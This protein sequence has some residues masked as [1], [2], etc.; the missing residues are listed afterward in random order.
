MSAAIPVA[1]LLGL[2][3]T[4]HCWGMCGGILAAFTLAIPGKSATGA[5]RDFLIAGF[6]LG[7]IFSYTAAGALAGALGGA[8]L[9]LA[10]RAPLFLALQ[11]AM[12]VIVIAS[13]LRLGGWLRAGGWM[14][15]AGARLWSRVQPWCRRLLPVD[16]MHRALALGAL[17]GWIP[18]GLVYA[19]LASSAASAGAVA[20]AATM[21]AFGAGTFPGMLAA[22]LAGAGLSARFST[23][24]A[25]RSL[26]VILIAAGVLG[27]LL[28][29][30]TGG[31]H[32]GLHLH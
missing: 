8:L 15:A 18:C 19:A 2:A 5:R 26:G 27:P 12:G 25:R 7:R 20:G 6:N 24:A 17:W 31:I 30:Y 14:E 22:G 23:A 32:H 11:I 29:I 3:S 28:S 10:W 1:F 21:L 16:R 13:G 9:S 4:L